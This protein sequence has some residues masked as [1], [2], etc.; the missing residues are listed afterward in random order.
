[1]DRFQALTAFVSVADKDGFAAAARSLGVS[2]S[3]VTRLVTA[4]E[5]HL[6][7]SLFQRT[8]R[9]VHLTDA[10]RRFLERARHI[11]SD[12]QEAELLAENERGVPS[13]RLAMSA[14]LMFGR[15]HVGPLICTFMNRYPSL[16]IDLQLA[17]RFASLIEEGIDVALRIGHMADSSLV[18][19]R[20]GATR[21]VVVAAPDYLVSAGRPI[22]PHELAA[23]RIISCTAITQERHWR[24]SDKGRDITADV[25]PSYVTN[26]AEAAL[27]HAA[28][29][30]GLV[31]VLGYQAIDQIRAGAL[32]V[33]LADYEPKPLPI[34]FAY[35]AAR[36]LSAKTRA[37]I[38]LAKETV[39]WNFVDF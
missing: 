10:G 21:R 34:Q 9:S 27:W 18:V 6:G 12:L 38:D 30:G 11:L 5:E 17:D 26:S 16:Q 39:D 7:I 23:H 2:A 24:F 19:R 31:Q 37:L 36:L 20:M 35:P 25:H 15:L 4:L 8:T 33:V 1:M 22:T 3:A 32:E 29:Q 13:G 28:R 14:P